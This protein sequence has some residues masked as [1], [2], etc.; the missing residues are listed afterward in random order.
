M[1]TVQW[2]KERSRWFQKYGWRFT[3]WF[4]PWSPLPPS[5]QFLSKPNCPR[6]N[7]ACIWLCNTSHQTYKNEMFRFLFVVRTWYIGWWQELVD[8]ALA[9]LSYT[10]P[11]L[12]YV[13]YYSK[14]QFQCD[15]WDLWR[16]FMWLNKACEN[17]CWTYTRPIPLIH[18]CKWCEVRAREC[19]VKFI[20]MTPAFRILKSRIANSFVFDTAII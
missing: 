11:Y 18:S 7:N 1:N 16:M 2:E 15:H 19:S 17:M 9:G 6:R 13:K 14:F 4:E 12:E 8:W 10:E 5:S 3:F 20:E